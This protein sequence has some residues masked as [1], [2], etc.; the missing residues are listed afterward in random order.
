[1]VEEGAVDGA[2]CREALREVNQL[3][4]DPS[5]KTSLDKMISSS[6]TV[7]RLFNDSSRLLG[8]LGAILGS[9]TLVP[10]L[11]G[12]QLALRFPG[13]LCMPGTFEP[14][15]FWKSVWHIDGL[16]S[17]ENG[18]P[19]GSIKNFTLLVGVCLQDVCYFS[20]IF[21][22]SVFPHNSFH[23]SFFRHWKNF[24]AIWSCFHAPIISWRDTFEPKGLKRPRVGWPSCHRC[25]WLTPCRCG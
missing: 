15:H 3:V 25:L 4:G 22:P 18:I 9:D 24:L 13:T 6:R 12:A 20:I 19:V 7:T 14:V 16:P 2:F 11:Q 17:P 5:V 23:V 21:F 1:M 10:Y 8:L